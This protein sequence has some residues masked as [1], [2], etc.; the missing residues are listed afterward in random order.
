VKYLVQEAPLVAPVA[1]NWALTI[2][3]LF[4]SLTG[5]VDDMP[6]THIQAMVTAY[7]DP[8]DYRRNYLKLRMALSNGI[9]SSLKLR[10]KGEFSI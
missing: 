1:L 7:L 9:D 4:A 2:H 5:E 8:S 6:P 3:R 10:L